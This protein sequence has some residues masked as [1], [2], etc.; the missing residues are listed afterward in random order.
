MKKCMPFKNNQPSSPFTCALFIM[1]VRNVYLPEMNMLS[2]ILTLDSRKLLLKESCQKYKSRILRPIFVNKP[3]ECSRKM[4]LK[5]G[6][7][8][9]IICTI[10]YGRRWALPTTKYRVKA[11]LF[12]P[13]A[14]F[15]VP[16]NALIG[17]C[18]TEC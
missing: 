11:H 15:F 6:F 17:R 3:I 2:R 13:T 12:V 7:T 9:L 1:A 10:K 8:F 4:H 18:L 5:Y 16:C 14:I